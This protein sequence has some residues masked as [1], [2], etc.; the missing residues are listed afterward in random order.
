M[1][2]IPRQVALKWRFIQKFAIFDQRFFILKG[3][4]LRRCSVVE[5][6]LH[7][8]VVIWH[9][10]INT[11]SVQLFIAVVCT[12]ELVLSNTFSCIESLQ[13]HVLLIL[14]LSF[15]TVF[16]HSVPLYTVPMSPFIKTFCW[17]FASSHFSITTVRQ[18]LRKIYATEYCW[19]FSGKKLRRRFEWSNWWITVTSQWRHSDVI[20]QLSNFSLA[21]T[22]AKLL[23]QSITFHLY[24]FYHVLRDYMFTC[25]KISYKFKISF[26]L[27]KFLTVILLLRA[28]WSLPNNT[29]ARIKRCMFKLVRNFTGFKFANEIK[30]NL[31][32]RCSLWLSTKNNTRVLDACWNLCYKQHFCIT[33]WKSSQFE[34]TF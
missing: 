23:C 31:C 9:M 11:E 15:F 28:K 1:V 20:F 25:Q 19:L 17:R 34:W 4:S 26:R 33:L 29:M 24:Y 21:S 27:N 2:E 12:A 10:N 16:C 30:Q 32:C 3:R 8:R 7:N 6:N 13:W 22:N 18:C 14:Q 5:S